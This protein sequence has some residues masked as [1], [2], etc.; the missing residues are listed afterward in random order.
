MNRF[1]IS[2]LSSLRTSRLLLFPWGFSFWYSKYRQSLIKKETEICDSSS[3]KSGILF[4]G[5]LDPHGQPIPKGLMTLLNSLTGI[6]GVEGDCFFCKK[7]L[8]LRPANRHHKMPQ[9]YFPNRREA[10][11][12]GNVVWGHVDC[13][14]TAHYWH[15]RVGMSKHKFIQYMHYMNW[16]EG[17]YEGD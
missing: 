10:D 5:C 6:E 15:D 14:A 8:N 4:A 9:R 12:N 3:E 1:H 17:I 11:A 7:P 13:H 16:W 2:F